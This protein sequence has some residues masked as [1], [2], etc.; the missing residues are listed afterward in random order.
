MGVA[1]DFEVPPVRMQEA[2]GAGGQGLDADLPLVHQAMVQ[3]AQGEQVREL[4][5][6]AVATP[7]TPGWSGE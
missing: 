5:L 6:Q 4:D 1:D 7:K 2:P 3:A